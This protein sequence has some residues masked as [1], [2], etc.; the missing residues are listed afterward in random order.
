MTKIEKLI[1]DNIK[2]SGSISLEEYM[3]VCLYHPEYGYYSKKNIIGLKGDFTTSPEVSQVFGELIASWLIYNFSNFFDNNFNYL[4]LGPGKGTLSKDIIRTIKFLNEDI[5]LK[6]DK[7]YFF[8]KSR[9]F[10]Q[11]LKNISKSTIISD[12]KQTEKKQTFI[13]ANEFFDALPINQY[14]YM[15]NNWYEKRITLNKN[16]KLVFNL[17]K[18]SASENIPFPKVSEI[19]S[20]FEYSRYIHLLLLEICNKIKNFGGVC[21]IIDYA[22][23]NNNY[24]NTLSAIFKHK[25]VDT[26]FLPGQTDLSTKPNYE[27]FEL[28]ARKNDCQVIGPMNQSFFLKKLGIIERFNNLIKSNPNSKELLL[29]QLQRLIDKDLMGDIFKVIIITNKNKKDLIFENV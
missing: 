12:I 15:G 7:L 19:G 8:E 10:L 16:N 17:S 27:F 3:T 25:L 24:K 4:E 11:Y 13:I 5:Y 26:F 29:S 9:K 18:T 23:A 21:I 14:V 20:I 28:L 2:I 6:I 1:K 22:K